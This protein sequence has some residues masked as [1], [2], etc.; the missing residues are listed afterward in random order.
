[1]IGIYGIFGNQVNQPKQQRAKAFAGMTRR[2]EACGFLCETVE[3]NDISLGITR[4]KDH[5]NKDL[6][7]KKVGDDLFVAMS[8]YARFAGDEK[9]SWADDMS[10][11]VGRVYREKGREQLLRLEGCFALV[12]CSAE[13]LFM[14]GDRVGSK[15]LYY[16]D[17]PDA[18][19]FAPDV[20]RVMASG[21][22]PKEQ[23]LE[24][25][26]EVL[27]SGFFLGDRTLVR[28]VMRFPYGSYLHRTLG[29]KPSAD[30]VRYWDFPEGERLQGEPSKYL[31]EEFETLMQK[32]VNDLA[33]LEENVAVPLSGGLDSRAI[34]CFLSRKQGFQTITYGP[35]DEYLPAKKVSAVLGAENHYFGK[36]VIAS[37]GFR[38]VINRLVL[39]HRNHCVLNQ[40][41]FDPIFSS[42]LHGSGPPQGIFDGV[43]LGILF[44]AAYT[45]EKFGARECLVF[46]GGNYVNTLHR[47]SHLS[48]DEAR[49]V[50]F[51]VF[52]QECGSELHG[53]GVG[54]SHKMY[55]LGRLR[56]YVNEC[57]ISRENY[58]YVFRPGFDYAL[59]DFGFSLPLPLRQGR[60]YRET[61]G[62]VFPS[63]MA[64][65]FKDSYGNH[66]KSPLE[67]WRRQSVQWLDRLAHRSRGRFP[68]HPTHIYY[69][70]WGKKRIDDFNDILCG[71][72]YLE[73]FFSQAQ[74]A[75]LFSN[76]RETGYFMDTLQRIL[77]AQ[78]FYKLSEF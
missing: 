9:F 44:S 36:K 7:L 68:Y 41:F 28:G 65:P 31:L 50:L 48:P 42:F 19:V 66:K 13:G 23:D 61:L 69:Y 52:E 64:V 37:D 53:G 16:F 3:A 38:H 73:E 74:L 35:R 49:N 63:V 39:E 4:R 27:V 70:L 15:N 60:L 6:A 54:R 77:L 57:G 22:V 78:H 1:M 51:R 56:R 21:L 34:A 5:P 24:G 20:P 72:N 67:K 62:A 46:Y 45:R 11:R 33:D 25:V 43:Y 2:A 71:R 40:Y 18:L 26:K 10:E 14:L 12:I 30:I 29:G 76:A 58:G 55:L 59:M 32:A 17:T 75:S 47:H 8:G